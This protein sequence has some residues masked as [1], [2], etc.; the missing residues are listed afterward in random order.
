[1][2]ESIRGDDQWRQRPSETV[3]YG[4]EA[5]RGLIDGGSDHQKRWEMRAETIKKGG[6]WG[7]GS[8]QTVA[9]GEWDHHRPWQMGQR[10]INTMGDMG[11][12]H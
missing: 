5:V 4:A 3:T 9:G 7:Q 1:M 6:R 8:S 10:P 11:R 2:T 12:D